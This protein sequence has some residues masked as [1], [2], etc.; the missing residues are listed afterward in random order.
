MTPAGYGAYYGIFYKT[1]RIIEMKVYTYLC[2][3]ISNVRQKD[4][5]MKPD[6]S[7]TIPSS[8]SIN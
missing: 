1:E 6:V 8:Y 7:I 5:G 3:R 4:D 2:A